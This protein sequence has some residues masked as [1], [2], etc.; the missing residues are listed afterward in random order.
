VYRKYG[1]ADDSPVRD[2]VPV[3][4][5]RASRRRLADRR[6]GQHSA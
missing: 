4:L 5:E 1:S 3:L 2:F 6:P